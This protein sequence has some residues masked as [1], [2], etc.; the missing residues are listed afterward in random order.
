MV[1]HV[2]L[3][4]FRKA[5]DYDFR[6]S[7]RADK[8]FLAVS[9]DLSRITTLL[10]GSKHDNLFSASTRCRTGVFATSIPLLGII[11]ELNTP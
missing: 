6:L 11:S 10:S 8:T 4:V 3:S 5:G 7:E 9:E 2:G 1:H